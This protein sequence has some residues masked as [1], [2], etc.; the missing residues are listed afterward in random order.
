VRARLAA[1]PGLK[2]ALQRLRLTSTRLRHAV[3]PVPFTELAAEDV[4][5]FAYQVVL[6]REPDAP[7]HA[8]Y[9]DELR[10]QRLTPRE[11]VDRLRT[12]DEY[13]ARTPIGGTT[14]LESL[15]LSRCEFIIGLPPAKRIVDLGG[16]H[17][18]NPWGAMVLLGYPYDFDELVIVDLP[19][20]DRHELYKSTGVWGDTA[21]PKGLVRYE[22]R[23]MADLSFADDEST[24]LIYSGQS[25]EHVTPDD[26]RKVVQEAFRIL[27]PGGHFALDTPNAPICRLHS[28][29]FID[30]DHKH[31][32]TL[33]ELVE[34]LEEGG[35]EVTER[36]G[37]NLASRSRR[38]G[39]FDQGEIA[40]HHGV[41]ADAESCYLLAVVAEKP[42]LS[43]GR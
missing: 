3:K 8:F 6:D 40:G 23:S 7:A 12:S 26:A 2:P 22:Y 34:L 33:A 28:A 13:R 17:T 36:K 31:E 10:A 20:D 37:L 29:D 18:A 15:H 19:G 32:Y 1:V 5:R 24:D 39:R 16:A 41:Y 25:I 11:I 35:F 42:H 27:R 43:L 30:P 38:D 9:L 14:L 21:T 4:I